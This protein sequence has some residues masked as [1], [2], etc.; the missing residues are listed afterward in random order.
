MMLKKTHSYYCHP[1]DYDNEIHP[2]SKDWVERHNLD[3]KLLKFNTRRII[4]PKSEAVNECLKLTKAPTNPESSIESGSEPLT[5][6]PLLKNLHE[7]SPSSEVMPLTYQDHS[8]RERHDEKVNST[9]KIQESKLVNLQSESSKPVNSSK[10]RQ[11]SKP[12]GKNTDS[13]KSV[14]P[15][16]LQKPKLKCELY[17]YTNHSTDDYYR[18][19]YYMKYK[20]EDHRTSNHNMYVASLKS[21]ENYKAQP[22]QYASHSKPILIAKAKDKPY[23]PPFAP[24]LACAST[25]I[26]LE[27]V[28]NYLSASTCEVMTILPQDTI[29]SFL[30]EEDQTNVHNHEKYT[31]VIVDEYSRYTWVHF[32]RKKSRA[33]EMI[34]AFIRMAKNQDDVKVKQLRTDN[35]TE[36]RNSELESFCDEK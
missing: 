1:P 7:A 25:T 26:R 21:S 8:P 32:L 17:H 13:S 29:M 16:P 14:R 15:K 11:E 35:G 27:I 4:V 19:L 22:C 30:S 5:P 28:K 18:I 3:N 31:I 20:R 24:S 23:Q 12:N 6:L 36:F 9:Q 33:A 2:K 34:M 10:I